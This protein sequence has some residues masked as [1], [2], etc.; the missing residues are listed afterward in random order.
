MPEL[1]LTSDEESA[2]EADKSEAKVFKIAQKP[3]R[4]KSN[5][6]VKDQT[7]AHTSSVSVS[8]QPPAQ[9]PGSEQHA[10]CL[11]TGATAG[12]AGSKAM[13]STL[14]STQKQDVTM[15]TADNGTAIIDTVGFGTLYVLNTKSQLRALPT[16]RSLLVLV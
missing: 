7:I 10:A 6:K 4:R 11:D 1:E 9:V 16:G 3:L 14:T 15:H 5:K 8:K 12:T 2:D 13:Q